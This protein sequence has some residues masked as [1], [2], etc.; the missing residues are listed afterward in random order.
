VVR[1]Y[2][3]WRAAR[4]RSSLRDRRPTP[5]DAYAVS[6]RC[7]PAS[8]WSGVDRAATHATSAAREVRPKRN[9]M[10]R[11]CLRTVE[12]A[13][14]SRQAITASLRPTQMSWATPRSRADRR[15]RVGSDVHSS[16]AGSVARTED[17]MRKVAQGSG[18]GDAGDAFTLRTGGPHIDAESGWQRLIVS[19]RRCWCRHV[20]FWSSLHRPAQPQP[21]PRPQGHRSVP[22]S[23]RPKFTPAVSWD[24]RTPARSRAHP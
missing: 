8:G 21:R 5:V 20:M 24:Q 16:R 23:R 7:K 19:G 6:A 9:C 3:K 11:T 4:S 13:R 22:R 14:P 12:T 18:R 15:R 17:C 1:R 10:R 2:P